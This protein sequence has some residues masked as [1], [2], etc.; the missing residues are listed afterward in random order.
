MMDEK[1]DYLSLCLIVKDEDEFLQEWLDY[2][3]LLGVQ[4]FYIYDNGSA[5]SIRQLLKKYIES[6][7]VIIH[8]I[9]GK[10]MQLVAYNHCLMNYGKN[11]KWIGF[12]DADEFI[13]SNRNIDFIDF[14]SQ[15]ENFGALAMNSIFFG[16]GGH[17]T[18][19]IGGQIINY[20]LRPSEKIDDDN[21]VKCIVQ[22]E[23]TLFPNSPHEFSY[24]EPFYCVNSKGFRVDDQRFPINVEDIQVNHYFTRSVEHINLK[25]NRLGGAGR[26]LDMTRIDR[27]DKTK[28]ELD[29]RVLIYL[30]NKLKTPVDKIMQ[31]P[32]DDNTF[33][34]FLHNCALIV[35]PNGNKINE[36]ELTVEISVHTPPHLK[37]FDQVQN[38]KRKHDWPVVKNLI[39]SIIREYP[40]MPIMFSGYASIC[41]LTRDIDEAKKTLQIALRK[42]GRSFENLRVLSDYFVIVE[43]F[44]KAEQTYR[45]LLDFGENVDILIR[46]LFTFIKQQKF[47]E[48]EPVLLKITDNYLDS[49]MVNMDFSHGVLVDSIKILDKI[50]KKKLANEIL[51][52]L[53]IQFPYRSEYRNKI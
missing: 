32:Q 19:P 42:F 27:V 24:K 13:V 3:I 51:K 6:G 52:K 25:I 7:W 33:I 20:R 45:E 15:Y 17:K 50:S 38:A 46:L 39:L 28:Q 35:S 18:K 47:D 4:R 36:G 34:E 37:L 9:N 53:R 10:A 16:T 2:H 40:N 41:L 22:P 31:Y 12:I 11:S 14:L 49:E 1:K 29:N 21:L 8:E 5:N 48:I 30:S 44:D 23:K 43:Q 26:K